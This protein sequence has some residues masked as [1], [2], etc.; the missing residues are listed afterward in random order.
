MAY[1][2]LVS[3]LPNI[4]SSESKSALPLT[5]DSYKE[6]CCRFISDK[7]KAVIEGLTLVPPK[8][9]ESTGS[10]FLDVWYTKERNLRF[11][12]AQIRAQKMKKDAYTL[13]D[14]CTADIVTAARTAVG[15]DSPYS[16]EQFLYEYRLKLLDDLKPLDSF[17]IDAVYAYGIKLMLVERMRKFDTEN[18]KSSYHKIYDT[19]L[20]ENV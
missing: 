10:A 15:M 19:I 1:Y 11:A 5:T 7:E 6:L 20:G 9:L 4:S 13:P 16:A 18:G 8:E 17:S 2:Y 14:G 12:L 3:Q